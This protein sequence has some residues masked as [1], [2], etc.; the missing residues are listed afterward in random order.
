MNTTKCGLCNLGFT[1]YLGQ[2]YYDSCINNCKLCTSPTVCS[3]CINGYTLTQNGSFCSPNCAI[4]NCIDCPSAENC[5]ICSPGY[6]LDSNSTSCLIIC[7]SLNC[8]YC[9]SN[10]NNCTKCKSGFKMLNYQ[11]YQTQC[12]QNCDLCL[13]SSTCL[14]CLSGYSPSYNSR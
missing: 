10:S 6:Y 7:S 3:F 13:S 4:S 12:I 9:Q 2:C 8:Q 5:S 14:S 1:L 11:C